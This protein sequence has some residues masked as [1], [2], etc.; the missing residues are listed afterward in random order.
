MG[1][2][3]VLFNHELIPKRYDEIELFKTGKKKLAGLFI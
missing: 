1:L 3:N 2:F